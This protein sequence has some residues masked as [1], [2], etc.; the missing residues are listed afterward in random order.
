MP[1]RDLD[2]W[3]LSAV[4]R[5]AVRPPEPDSVPDGATMQSFRVEQPGDDP[6]V[7]R[8]TFVL[9]EPHVKGSSERFNQGNEGRVARAE[10]VVAAPDADTA[11]HKSVDLLNTYLDLLTFLTQSPT[12]VV[13]YQS[14]VN[15][16]KKK[17]ADERPGQQQEVIFFPGQRLPEQPF[18]PVELLVPPE[19]ERT[20][21]ALSWFR[22][23][24]TSERPEDRF[25]AYFMALEILSTAIVPE[26]ADV[27]VCRHCGKATGIPKVP[28]EGILY[29]VAEVLH[30]TRRDWDKVVKLRGKVV[31]APVS[32]ERLHE[33]IFQQAGLLEQ[34]LIAA[35]KH[36]L[37]LRQEGLPVPR[38]RVE[39]ALLD[40]R[41]TRG[42]GDLPTDPDQAT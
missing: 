16:S 19:D 42:R 28:R 36:I 5:M 39:R 37:R 2:K 15:V 29:V 23:G 32:G 30:K 3:Q 8:V 38:F 25:L 12:H 10:V 11:H 4:V 18:P 17:L 9:E 41:F 33:E 22:Q 26:R 21:K 13:V 1:Q 6:E 31:H 34:V 14:L 24:L 27:H 40:L 7:G 35:L 20:K